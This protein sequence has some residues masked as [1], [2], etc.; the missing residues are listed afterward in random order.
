AP[1]AVVPS[2]D[3]SRVIVVG[4][5]EGDGTL[6][7]FATVSYDP[8]TGAQ[9]WAARY[10]G[11]ASDADQAAAAA[12]SPDGAA[13]YVTGRSALGLGDDPLVAPSQSVT[14]AYDATGTTQ[15]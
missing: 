9:E 8:A 6:A 12:F 14:I 3:G 11:A 10:N 4:G 1:Q 7:D 2:P 15:T 5:S 13:L